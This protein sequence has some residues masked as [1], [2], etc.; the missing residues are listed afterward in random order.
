M[1]SENTFYPTNIA[2]LG[3]R[4]LIMMSHG[5]GHNYQWYDHLGTHMASY[6]YVF[7]SHENNT[8]PGVFAA[9]TTTLEHTNVFVAQVTSAGAPSTPQLAPLDNLVD[10]DQIMWMGH[11]RGGE[12]VAIA[13]DRVFDGLFV[14]V[15]WGLS[16]LVLVSSVAPVDFQGGGAQP[17]FVHGGNYHLW[18]GSSDADVNGCANCN[19]CQT[20]H[21]HDR[22]EQY[23]QSIVLQGAGHGNFHNQPAAG[24][25]ASGPCLI[26]FP[27]THAIMRG[28]LLP[29]AKR[30]F[31]GDIP[32][33]DFLTRQWEEFKPIG[34]PATAACNPPSGTGVDVVVNMTYR[35]GSS[36]G[37]FV[38]DDFQTNA[39]TAV[40]SSGG[41]VA[42]AGL[43]DVIEGL[44]DDNNGDFT[45]N[46]ADLMNAI[47]LGGT[48]DQTRGL[49]FSWTGAAS[50]EWA[51]LV[52]QQDMTDDTY[53]SFR[54]AQ[55]SRNPNTIAALADLTFDVVLRD[56]GGST[57]RINIG[58]YGGG[59]EE[60]YQ[61][62]TCGAGTG[63]AAEHEIIRMRLSDFLNNGSGLDLSNIVAVRFEFAGAG[64][65]P[66]GRLNID[67]ITIT[68][69]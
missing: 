18:T 2:A 20:Y 9:S 39:S 49:T 4:P 37:N 23:R 36:A 28:Y 58:A 5:N 12:G 33:L 14:P 7:M 10:V 54:A 59:V 31:E 16:D 64:T 41:A 66:V 63:W 29:L 50:I 60:P 1:E 53:L 22:A 61:R 38:I 25:V 27:K 43:T 26:G 19:L 44:N 35:D 21:L 62:T 55:A 68:N 6:G 45:W 42:L 24:A 69:N 67:E 57:S 51:V 30:Y 3:P 13:Y 48:G 17:G 47:T 65:A 34:A 15:G 32:S 52:A 46:P 11:S 8:V 40:S 56:A